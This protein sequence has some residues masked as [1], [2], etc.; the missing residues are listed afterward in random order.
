MAEVTYVNTPVGVHTLQPCWSC[1]HA[2]PDHNGHGCSWS[3]GLEPVKG[4]V[5]EPEVKGGS[6]TYRIIDCPQYKAEKERTLASVM[7]AHTAV[8]T[9]TVPEGISKSLEYWLKEGR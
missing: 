1:V 6:S 5:A 4:W 9:V 7:P 2:V 3:R 8:R